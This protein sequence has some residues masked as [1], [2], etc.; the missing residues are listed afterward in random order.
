MALRRRLPT[1]GVTKTS[2]GIKQSREVLLTDFD[3]KPKPALAV[4]RLKPPRRVRSA[5]RGTRAGL[6]YRLARHARVPKAKPRSPTAPL[7]SP[8]TSALHAL[9]IAATPLPRWY[10]PPFG[11]FGTFTPQSRRAGISQV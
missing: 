10:H 4:P 7:L 1:K 6:V 8:P 5:R 2:T 3:S 11:T 9:F